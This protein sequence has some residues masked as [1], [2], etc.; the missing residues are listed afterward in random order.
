[1][2]LSR[3]SYLLSDEK[4]I[5]REFWNL[6]S[7]PNARPKY[8]LSMDSVDFGSPQGIQHVQLRNM[9]EIFN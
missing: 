5:E 3:D 9:R 6:H 2:Y 4:V 1:M 7:I 8:V